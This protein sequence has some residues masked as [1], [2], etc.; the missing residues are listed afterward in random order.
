MHTLRFG[1]T[2]GAGL[3]DVLVLI[4]CKFLWTGAEAG[5]VSPLAS[6]GRV[7]AQQA[8]HKCLLNIWQMN[9]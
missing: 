1:D 6:P 5:V 3:G 2:E 8:F 7:D 9:E 4:D